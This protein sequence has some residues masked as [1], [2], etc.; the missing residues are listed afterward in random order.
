LSK[1]NQ[2]EQRM[3]VEELSDEDQTIAAFTSYAYWAFE[4][5]PTGTT[6]T[7]STTVEESDATRKAMR[8]RMAMREA[9]RHLVGQNGNYDVAVERFQ[10]TVQWRKVRLF[11]LYFS[12]VESSLSRPDILL[13]K[14]S[15]ID[16]LKSCF[17]QTT[18]QNSSAP[19]VS[20]A[21]IQLS[22][23]D[24][25][26]CTNLETI[27]D[28]DLSIQTMAIRGHDK[29][30]RPII[31]RL[32]RQNPWSTASDVSSQD[33]EDGFKWAQ[34]YMAERA[35]AVTEI[36]S[37]GKCEQ[38]TAFLALG[39]YDSSNAPPINVM[40]RTI[41]ALQTNYPERLGKAVAMDVPFWISALITIV[42]PFL[43]TKTRDK[44][45]VLGAST[46]DRAIR[47]IVDPDQA[48]PFMLSD[49]KLHST[50]D[51]THQLRHVPFYEL[52]DFDS[53][54]SSCCVVTTTET[55]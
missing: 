27:I 25:R 42:K 46:A 17:S 20:T 18:T 54:S 44:L 47:E 36:R 41:T 23:V 51:V 53:T 31:I 8:I 22:D 26:F 55:S 12:F 3:V 16:L 10:H 29:A 49:G 48:M 38:L 52:Y 2:N 33:D 32:P 30:N 11:S 7:T 43:S 40:I 45:V 13:G 28:R 15:K 35:M 14:E 37:K 4:Q 50:I 6:T 19:N 24:A 34:L 1:K 9:R 5:I 39:S 21:T